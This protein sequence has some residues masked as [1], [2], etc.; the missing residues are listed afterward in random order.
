M[1]SVPSTLT[2]LVSGNVLKVQEI[3]LDS[4]F[5][6]SDM[7]ELIELLAEVR[8]EK[9]LIEDEEND[10]ITVSSDLE[11][12]EAFKFGE[13]QNHLNV[14]AICINRPKPVVVENPFEIKLP[15]RP[16]GAFQ[17]EPPKTKKSVEFSTIP[18]LTPENTIPFDLRLP[19][20]PE[21]PPKHLAICDSCDKDIYGIRYKCSVCPDYDLCSECENVN[22]EKNFH[23]QEHF[24]LKINK[25]VPFVHKPIMMNNCPSLARNNNNSKELEDRLAAAEGRIQALELKFRAGEVKSR[26]RK[27][28]LM[29]Q[30][31][32]DQTKPFHQTAPKRKVA[33]VVTVKTTQPT[34]SVSV[35]QVQPQSPQNPLIK[36][37]NQFAELSVSQ[38]AP[39]IV[40]KVET[41]P[42]T[43][44]QEPIVVPENNTS[45][46]TDHGNPETTDD[47]VIESPLSFTLKSMG[48][49]KETVSNVMA[50]YHDLESC[51]N[52]LLDK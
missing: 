42:E 6:F 1:N 7:K 46:K 45:P 10:W 49:D 11:L 37:E 25:P 2:I 28:H 35:P 44:P 13:K 51:L 31:L 15:T 39:E 5:D 33:N 24:F 38:P 21:N 43:Q 52:Y 9:L 47:D 30:Q 26:W 27:S 48:F 41:A 19:A 22:L 36:L 3:Q 16:Q 8:L 50:K 17:Q 20:K 29:K 12:E 23:P 14:K 4:S 34:P 32:E 18:K 40:G